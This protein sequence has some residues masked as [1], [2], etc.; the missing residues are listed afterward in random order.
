MV[1]SKFKDKINAIHEQAKQASSSAGVYIGNDTVLTRLYN[2]QI[3]YVDTRDASETPHLIM[4]G[5]WEINVTSLVEQLASQGGLM[6]DVG[7]TY[8]YFALIAG[9]SGADRVACIEAN[10][11]YE[12][13]IRK[14][15]TVNNVPDNWFVEI[16]AT[17]A[18]AGTTKLFIEGDDWNS[19]STQQSGGKEKVAEVEVKTLDTIL[20]ENDA[21]EVSV[22]K[23]DIEGM[24]EETYQGMSE[25][26]ANSPNLKLLIEFS[27]ENYKDAKGFFSK[28]QEDFSTIQVMPQGD[29]LYPV[30]S[31]ADIEKYADNWMMVLAEK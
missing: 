26:I 25:T 28:I 9:N 12:D 15:L 3:M 8:G 2:S 5:Y 31:Y 18:K 22:L 14:N 16:S 19:A 29:Q 13:Y 7:S 24:E 17:G 10:P 27:P 30:N 4:D 23:I 11:V 21:T 6:V 1:I 20:A